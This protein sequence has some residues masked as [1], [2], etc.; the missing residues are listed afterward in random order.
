M[1]I[2]TQPAPE[3]YNGWAD[4][5][6]CDIWVNVI[7]WNKGE[8]RSN[9]VDW[10]KWQDKPIPQEVHD[11]WKNTGAFKDGMA[12]I[13][14]TCWHQKP[15]NPRLR[16]WGVDLDKQSAIDAYHFSWSTSILVN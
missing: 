6:R 5:W 15:F 8:G 16:L 7:P 1:A 13:L 12:V 11:Y 4:F 2:T 9:K 3:D 10:R 14:G